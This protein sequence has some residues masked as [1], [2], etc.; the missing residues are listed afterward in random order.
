MFMPVGFPLL[1]VH[2]YYMVPSLPLLIGISTIGVYWIRGRLSQAKHLKFW[3]SFSLILIIAI[4]VLG[5][6]RALER[7]ERG[8]KNTPYEQLTLE[9]HLS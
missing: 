1:L 4:S 6:I 5:S 2:D 8:L 3:L 9:T 7:F